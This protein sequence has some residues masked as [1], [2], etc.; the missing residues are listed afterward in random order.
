MDENA[1]E[2]Y[3]REGVPL[4]RD[5]GEVPV[6]R[7]YGTGS[8]RWRALWWRVRGALRWPVRNRG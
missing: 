4:G 2:K 5:T 6:G 8:A 3:P 1:P 7:P